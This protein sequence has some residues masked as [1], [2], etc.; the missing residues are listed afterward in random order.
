MQ[1]Y[2]DMCLCTCI[3]NK[4]TV[5]AFFHVRTY[6]NMCIVFYMRWPPRSYNAEKG[7]GRRA[8]TESAAMSGVG[9]RGFWASRPQDFAITRL[10]SR[11]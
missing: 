8:E 11:A 5:H 9:A 3:G 7:F 4:V 10:L 2:I 6:V 1:V